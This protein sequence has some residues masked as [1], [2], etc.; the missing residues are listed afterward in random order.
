[1]PLVNRLRCPL[2]G[3]VPRLGEENSLKLIWLKREW[4][5]LARCRPSARQLQE[6]VPLRTSVVPVEGLTLLWSGSPL[7]LPKSAVTSSTKQILLAP[8]TRTLVLAT[9]Y[10]LL[11]G[12]IGPNRVLKNTFPLLTLLLQSTCPLNPCPLP[13]LQSLGRP[14]R[15]FYRLTRLNACCLIQLG[16]RLR[17]TRW[18]LAFPRRVAG[19]GDA[20]LSETLTLPGALSPRRTMTIP[21]GREVNILCLHPILPR[22]QIAAVIVLETPNVCPHLVVLFGPPPRTRR[23]LNGRQHRRRCFS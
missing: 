5:L 7:K 8:H 19:R 15:L 10:P 1:M 2:A 4:Q 14:H 23:L 18:L 22:P 11:P 20:K 17:R 13:V 6:R 16:V 3:T 21:L 9:L 12:K